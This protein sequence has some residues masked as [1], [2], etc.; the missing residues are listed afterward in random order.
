[1][2]RDIFDAIALT[3]M[4]TYSKLNNIFIV[5]KKYEISR[6]IKAINKTSLSL[7]YRLCRKSYSIL[8]DQNC[9][10][11]IKK[12]VFG[13]YN[14]EQIP[15]VFETDN[16]TLLLQLRI[17]QMMENNFLR[18]FMTD[19]E[20]KQERLSKNQM[21][22]RHTFTRNMSSVC[23]S[24]NIEDVKHDDQTTS[25]SLHRRS[26]FNRVP[27][28]LKFISEEGNTNISIFEKDPDF[29]LS[30]VFGYK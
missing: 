29:Y 21:I 16:Y 25:K 23:L 12:I 1:L 4:C 2:K 3:F 7:M 18:G 30:G 11:E 8:F 9:D 10:A 28:N 13:E 24:E 20:R 17:R 5:P 27:T 26:I 19:E 6:I 22:I 14:S 15:K